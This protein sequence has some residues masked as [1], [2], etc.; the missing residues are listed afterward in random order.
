MNSYG[1]RDGVC[2][3]GVLLFNELSQLLL[4]DLDAETFGVGANGSWIELDRVEALYG[5]DQRLDRWS[6]EQ[7]PRLPVDDRVERAARAERDHGPPA[8]YSDAN[9][10][11]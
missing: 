2:E 4:E 9:H 6:I 8:M 5:V 1:S 7:D 11:G 10:A 3:F